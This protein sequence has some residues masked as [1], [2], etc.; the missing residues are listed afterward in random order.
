[1]LCHRAYFAGVVGYEVM[2][3]LATRDSR[4]RNTS[5]HT[6][7]NQISTLPSVTPHRFASKYRTAKIGGLL[8]DVQLQ[9]IRSPLDGV[10]EN[11]AA[12]EERIV[13]PR[14]NKVHDR[15][16]IILWIYVKEP[17]FANQ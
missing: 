11:K 12:L 14:P 15:V 1:M 9:Y 16:A 4:L 6:E 3:A 10:H 7:Q 2:L 17:D 8:R 5:L 13:A